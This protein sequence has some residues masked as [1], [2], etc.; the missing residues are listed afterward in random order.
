MKK[1][2]RLFLGRFLWI[3]LIIIIELVLILGLFT[4]LRAIFE[5]IDQ[6][7]NL[8]LGLALGLFDFILMVYIV[9]SRANTSYKISWLFLV[10][11]FPFIGGIIYLMFGNKNTSKRTLKKIEPLRKATKETVTSP[12]IIQELEATQDGRAALTIAK[13]I[14]KE[15]GS[16]LY[17]HTE[18]HYYK[19]GEDA[20]P[21]MLEELKKAKHYIFLEYFIIEK[22]QFWNSIVDILIE[23]ARDGVDVRVMYD[24]LGSVSTLPTSYPNYLRKHGIKCCAY[25]RLKPLMDIK[26]N[27]RDHRKIL[28]IDGTVGFTGGINLADEYINTKVRFGHWKDNAIML[29]GRGVYGLTMLF[30][31]NWVSM[32]GGFEELSDSKYV[33]NNYNPTYD[34]PSDG[35]IQPYGD[36]PFGDDAVGEEVY[37]KLINSAE[38][39][40][41]ITT[42]Y[43]IIDEEMENTLCSVAKSGVNVCLLVPHIPD[44]KMVFNVTRSYYTKLIEAGVKV[45]EYTPGFVH[46][47]VFI[48]DDDMATVGTINLDY[49]SLYLHLENGVFI[50]KAKIIQD[51]KAD[52]E[53]AISNSELI[54]KERFKKIRRGK[55]V[56][57]A[58]LRVLAPLL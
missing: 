19:V 13:Y 15:S 20:W 52:F 56:L 42:P 38:K 22:G 16:A 10:G 23:K 55:G 17:D 27:N 32:N 7:L 24:D 8:G 31:Q 51:M 33:A 11:L 34:Y 6:Y 12:R 14:Q 47:K 41:Y 29:K 39:Y 44:K 3:G 28:V 40:I 54:T 35:Y 25:N 9:N 5:V 46:E 30:L 57:W 37:I 26:L 58:L 36:I 53:E 21:V 43:L 45:Y 1:F 4:F 50:Y 48:V 49:R 2:I 18:S